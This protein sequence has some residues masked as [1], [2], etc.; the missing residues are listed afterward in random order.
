MSAAPSKEH[1]TASLNGDQPCET[2][3]SALE[4]GGLEAPVYLS[5]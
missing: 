4:A 5:W 3:L 1:T 2:T